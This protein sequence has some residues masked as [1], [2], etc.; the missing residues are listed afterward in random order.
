MIGSKVKE[1]NP[2]NGAPEY[3][4]EKILMKSV[5]PKYKGNMNLLYFI[6]L[7]LSVVLSTNQ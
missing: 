4:M 2:I 6:G 5:R 3:R 7:V 1:S